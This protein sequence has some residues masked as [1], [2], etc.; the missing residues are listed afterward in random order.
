MRRVLLWTGAV[1]GLLIM[2]AVVAGFILNEPLPKGK[3]GPEADALAQ[4]MLTAID[5]AAWDSTGVVQWTFADRH[6]FLWDRTR[7]FIEVEWGAKSVLLNTQT[8][9]GRAWKNEVELMGED[10]EVVLKQAWS[11][12]CN[13]SFWLNAPAKVFDPGT[14]RSLVATDGGQN[15]LLITYTSGG[16]TPGDSYLWILD[17]NGLPIKWK[18]WVKILP[19]GGLAASWEDWVT[20]PSGAK[21]ASTHKNSGLTLKITNIEGAVKLEDLRADDPFVSLVNE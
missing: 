13:D 14:R 3:E 18:M 4:K 20:L 11:L 5:K 17:D 16:V 6:H 2:A 8:L 7:D 10:K 9:E 1:F 15:A 21:L 12:F 19:I